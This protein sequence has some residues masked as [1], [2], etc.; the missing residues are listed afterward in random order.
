MCEICRQNPCAAGC[1]NNDEE[2]LLECSICG[3]GIFEG[4]NYF[5]IND[6]IICEDCTLECQ[7]TAERDVTYYNSGKPVFSYG[8]KW[9]D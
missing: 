1:P 4:D 6:T 9:E 8:D 5:E 2:P 3:T 7:H